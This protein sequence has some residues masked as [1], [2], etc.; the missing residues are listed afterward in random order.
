M[1]CNYNSLAS[2][3]FATQSF[4]VKVDPNYLGPPPDLT[5]H[6]HQFTTD[7]IETHVDFNPGETRHETITCPAS[8][9][10]I[11]D[12]SVVVSHVDQGTG[13]PAD[14]E[15][16][17]ARSLTAGSYDFTITNHATGQAQV[18]LFGVCLSNPSVVNGHTH[19]LLI[20]STQF[21]NTNFGTGGYHEAGSATCPAGTQPIA[22]GF[23][24]LG[25]TPAKVVKSEQG[26]LPGGTTGWVFGFV[27]SSPGTVQVSV[28]CMNT[29]LPGGTH[30]HQLQLQEISRNVSVAPGTQVHRLSCGTYNS[31]AKG[32]TAT[33]DFDSRMTLAGTTPEPINRDFTFFN[34]TS[35]PLGAHIDLICLRSRTTTALPPGNTGNLTNTATVSGPLSDPLGFNNSSSVTVVVD[36]DDPPDPFVSPLLG[37]APT[38][39]LRSGHGAAVAVAVKAECGEQAA[40]R[41]KIAVRAKVRGAHGRQHLAV[42]ASGRLNAGAGASKT[43]SVPLTH[44]GKRKLDSWHNDRRVTVKTTLAGAERPARE[45]LRLRRP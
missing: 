3:G 9:P 44:R 40:C 17:E 5:P 30:S 8:L 36:S 12:G 7:K 31:D 19:P 18:K 43:L 22:P 28:K 10:H 38:A 14:I 45:K 37:L 21:G 1:T 16:S 2:G 34:P 4:I 11:T 33:Y 39:T 41:G 27:L 24:F 42:V 25:G 15:I 23:K 20:S 29:K 26:A 13:T 32:I 35:G 6:D